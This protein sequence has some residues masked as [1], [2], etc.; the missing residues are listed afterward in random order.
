VAGPTDRSVALLSIHPRYADAILEGT[1][2]VEFR[3][4]SYP[5]A[6]RFIVIYATAPVRRVI[7]WFEINGFSTGSP[8]DLWRRYGE[9]S[10]V[11]GEAFLRYFQACEVGTAIQVGRAVRL[12]DPVSLDDVAPG[13]KAPQSYRYLLDHSATALGVPVRQTTKR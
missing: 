11:T 12:P 5:S 6:A 10:H 13:L 4:S 1:K 3:R 9:T 7:G 2:Q 8:G